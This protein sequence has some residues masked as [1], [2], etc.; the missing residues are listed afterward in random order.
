MSAADYAD[1]TAAQIDVQRVDH[2]SFTV[3]EIERSARFYERFG[4]A[5]V[6]RYRQSGS[7]LDRAVATV[8]ADMEIQILRRPDGA[9]LELIAYTKQ[10]SAR[11]ARN[12]VVGAGHIAFVVADIEAAYDELRADGVEFLSAPNTDQY[13]ERWVYLRDPD[14][15]TVELMQP[16]EGSERLVARDDGTAT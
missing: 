11:A 5:R 7:E 1:R 4:F 2:V 13:G 15:I 12:C 14:G 8:P 16:G 3:A 6:N 10:P 9:M